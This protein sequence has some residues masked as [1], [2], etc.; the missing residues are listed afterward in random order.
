VDAVIGDLPGRP[1]PVVLVRFADEI[2]P[3]AAAHGH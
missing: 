2:I 3:A 1:D